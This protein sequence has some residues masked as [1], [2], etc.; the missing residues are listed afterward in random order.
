MRGGFLKVPFNEFPYP[1]KRIV[2]VKLTPLIA[3]QIQFRELSLDPVR[4]FMLQ[5]QSLRILLSSRPKHT[6][7]AKLFCISADGSNLLSLTSPANPYGT[8]QANKK[9]NVRLSARL[10]IQREY[11]RGKPAP[12]HKVRNNPRIHAAP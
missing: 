2:L 8:R 1:D 7:N 4:L 11:L 10:V 5:F 12:I 3:L 6:I 9:F